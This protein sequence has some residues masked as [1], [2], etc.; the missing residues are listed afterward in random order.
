MNKIENWNDGHRHYF[1]PS[2]KDDLK[3]ARKFLHDMKWG[4]EGCPFYLVW[5]YNDMPYMLKTKI[6]EYYLKGI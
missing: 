3:I 1:D 4:K 5:P 2:S 6:T